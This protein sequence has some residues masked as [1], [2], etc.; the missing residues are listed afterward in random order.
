MTMKRLRIN[1]HFVAKVPDR[2][3]V[4]IQGKDGYDI[5]TCAEALVDRAFCP[6]HKDITGAVHSPIPADEAPAAVWFTRRDGWTGEVVASAQMDE[7]IANGLI[8]DG[9]ITCTKGTLLLTDFKKIIGLDMRQYCLQLKRDKLRVL[10][11]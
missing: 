6:V 7:L 4:L 9:V 3:P 2:C 10:I 11:Y 5:G 1:R 8:N